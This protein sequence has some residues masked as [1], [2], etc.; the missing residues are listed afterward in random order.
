VNWGPRLPPCAV[1]IDGSAAHRVRQR[2]SK[3]DIMAVVHDRATAHVLVGALHASGFPDTDMD[4]LEPAFVLAGAAMLVPA[5]WPA[6]PLG[7]ARPCRRRFQ[8]TRPNHGCRPPT[9]H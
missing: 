7:W 1:R 5:T 6:S 9:R 2:V 8:G 4:I 3:G